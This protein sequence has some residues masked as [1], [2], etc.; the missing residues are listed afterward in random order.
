M[1][2]GIGRE[3][4]TNGWVALQKGGTED[5]VGKPPGGAVKCVGVGGDVT[6]LY[7]GGSGDIARLPLGGVGMGETEAGR[8]MV[9]PPVQVG[10]FVNVSDLTGHFS[11]SFRFPEAWGGND[12]HRGHE[13]SCVLGLAIRVTVPNR[14]P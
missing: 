10:I 14:V 12:W 4:G 9:F 5:H 11:V 3:V 2:T 13:G 1:G 8:V 7:I 6:M